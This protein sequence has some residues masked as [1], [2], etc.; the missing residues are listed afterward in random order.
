MEQPKNKSCKNTPLEEMTAAK[1]NEK[2]KDVSSMHTEMA[3]MAIVKNEFN[4]IIVFAKEIKCEFQYFC[5]I[6]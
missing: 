1:E 4:I 3:K 6:R 5:C 2:S